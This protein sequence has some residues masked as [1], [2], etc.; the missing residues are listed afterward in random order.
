M[1]IDTKLNALVRVAKPGEFTLNSEAILGNQRIKINNW[2]DVCIA[3]RVL[4]EVNWLPD[5]QHN[6][7]LVDYLENRGDLEVIE[8]S[9][10]ELQML[11]Q[12]VH[13]YDTGLPVVINT[14]KAHARA[15]SSD[16]IWIE[17]KSVS[18]PAE[19]SSIT[20]E[21]ERALNI[22]G[23]AGSSFRFAG[24]AQGSDWLG[25]IPGSVL[26]GV[27]L[28]Y[29]ISLAAT[30][31]VELLKVAGPVVN[32]VAKLTLDDEDRDGEPTQEEIDE[33][34][35]AI[36]DRAADVIIDD[37]V[38]TFIEHLENAEYPP[39]VRNQ[40]GVA[41]RAT[42][43]TIREMAESNRAVFE[44]SESGKNIV[45]QVHGDNNQITVQNFPELPNSH[46]EALPP[47]ETE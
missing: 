43:K 8:L 5:D 31:T 18:D 22:A 3:L 6:Q 41:V 25:F 16:T 19:L 4:Q 23:Q 24:V 47:G 32:A 11:E 34:I 30:V 9:H 28:N 10:Q 35:K 12:A 17:L 39:E 7:L 33:R 26:A 20:T 29:C 14:L 1:R 15:T 36:K 37:A 13:R 21:I 44:T 27:A 2:K 42:T 45:I 40:V 46:Q 38:R